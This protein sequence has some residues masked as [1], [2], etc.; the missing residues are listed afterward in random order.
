VT[1]YRGDGFQQGENVG[2]N[3]TDAELASNYAV[4]P[5]DPVN[6]SDIVFWLVVRAHHEPRNL[7]EEADHLPYHYEEFSIV[8]RSFRNARRRD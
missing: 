8:P 4:G 2:L 3:C 6:G 7:A 5:L 1:V